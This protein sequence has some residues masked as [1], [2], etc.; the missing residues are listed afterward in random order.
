MTPLRRPLIVLVAAT[1]AASAALPVSLAAASAVPA[2]ALPS[3]VASPTP[4]FPVAALPASG[5][6]VGGVVLGGNQIGQAGCVGTNRPSIGGNAG[7]TSAQT[8]GAVL[9]FN[10][11]QIGQIAT[12]I[13]PTIIGSVVEAPIQESA[14]PIT[15]TVG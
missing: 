5:A 12:V 6:P 9:S 10:G 13:G 2:A 1:C 8:C 14:A 15:N 7:S 11:P 3:A 4:T